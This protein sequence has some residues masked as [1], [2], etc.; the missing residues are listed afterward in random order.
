[1]FSHVKKNLELQKYQNECD[2]SLCCVIS[3]KARLSLVWKQIWLLCY[4][5]YFP[6]KLSDQK[7][8]FLVVYI[9]LVLGKVIW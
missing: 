8:D 4:L 5:S 6:F 9:F 2:Q 3:V 7:S 1:M